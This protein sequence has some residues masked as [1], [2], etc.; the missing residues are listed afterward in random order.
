MGYEQDKERVQRIERLTDAIEFVESAVEQ[1]IEA[2]RW[3]NNDERYL[4]LVR[5]RN[6]LIEAMQKEIEESK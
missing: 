4:T 6:R 3:D 1:F 2:A 5:L